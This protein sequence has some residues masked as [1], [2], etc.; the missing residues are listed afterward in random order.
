MSNTHRL[1]P[2]P[3]SGP[4]MTALPPAGRP[5]GARLIGQAIAGVIQR[6]LPQALAGA[7]WRVHPPRMCAPCL[8]AFDAWERGNQEP[9]AA[10]MT[11]AAQDGGA[12][13]DWR[14]Q[15]PEELRGLVPNVERSVTTVNGTEVCKD[16]AAETLAG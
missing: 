16:H 8:A 11:A 5:D 4:P 2:A 3:E 1:R 12:P 15:L 6:E 10:A 13:Q 7:I 14:A 9:I